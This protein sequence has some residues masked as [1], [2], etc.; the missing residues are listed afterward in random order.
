[1]CVYTRARERLMLLLVK[2]NVAVRWFETRQKEK[3]WDSNV[4]HVGTSKFHV[5]PQTLILSLIKLCL[6]KT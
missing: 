1:M 6:L 5:V 3:P 4:H 2:V